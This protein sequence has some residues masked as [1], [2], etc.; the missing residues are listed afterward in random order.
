[1]NSP[2]DRTYAVLVYNKMQ[3]DFTWKTFQFETLHVKCMCLV[4]KA[5]SVRGS[6]KTEVLGNRTLTVLESQLSDQPSK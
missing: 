3:K 5:Q 6:L 2:A 4:Q 1:M